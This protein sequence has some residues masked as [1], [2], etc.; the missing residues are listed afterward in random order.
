MKMK[1]KIFASI[2]IIVL[3][4]ACSF[5]GTTQSAQANYVR[6]CSAYNAAFVGVYN[7][8]KAGKLSTSQLDQAILLESQI[9]PICTGPLP[10]DPESATAQITAAVTTL[11]VLEAVGATK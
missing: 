5:T 4:T 1:M 2:S 11:T 10:K 3:F 6:A 9:T 8:V 7:A